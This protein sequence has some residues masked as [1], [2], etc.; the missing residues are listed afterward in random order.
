MA[1][2]RLNNNSITSITA[3]PSAVAVDNTP[4]FHAYQSSPQGLP[5]DSWT[6]L[7]FQTEILDSDSKFSSNRF[8]PTVS[9]KYFFFASYRLNATQD[10]NE[11]RIAIYKNGSVSRMKTKTHDH[12]E[13]ID[14]V[15]VIDSNTTDYF[16]VYAWQNTGGQRDIYADGDSGESDDLGIQTQFGAYK[17]IT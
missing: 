12:R 2:T 1:I 10:G 6:K 13:S 16:E 7:N 5:N 17:I 11:Y 4:A 9:G 8:T 14:I 15:T 3:L